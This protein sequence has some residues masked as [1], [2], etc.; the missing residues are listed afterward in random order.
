VKFPVFS[1]FS[2]K[3]L[4]FT[5]K[6]ARRQLGISNLIIVKKTLPV[7]NV[8]Q[9]CVISFIILTQLELFVA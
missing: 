4:V 6:I 5:P 9:G 7:P 2:S 3:S 8:L 1:D